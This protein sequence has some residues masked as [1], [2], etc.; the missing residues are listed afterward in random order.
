VLCRDDR[1]VNPVWSRQ[2]P[3]QRLGVEPKEL[4]GGHSLFLARPAELAA[5]LVAGDEPRTW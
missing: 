4:G 2:S 5:L 3:Q 1:A